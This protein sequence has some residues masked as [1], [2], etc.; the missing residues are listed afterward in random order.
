[1]K[2]GDNMLKQDQVGQYD[3]TK[4]TRIHSTKKKHSSA[5]EA[6]ANQA[7]MTQDANVS[8][9]SDDAIMDAKNWV[10]NGSKL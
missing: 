3:T 1:M 6:W 7:H 10:D 5:T 4:N 9:P 8:I 2:R